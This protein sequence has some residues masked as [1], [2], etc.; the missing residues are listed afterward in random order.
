MKKMLFAIMLSLLFGCAAQNQL[1][2]SQVAS[3]KAL[4]T[5][6]NVQLSLAV[7][8][9]ALKQYVPVADQV[10]VRQFAQDLLQLSIGQ[11]DAATIAPL[12]PKLS[13]TAQKYIQPLIASALYAL[14]TAL[15]SLGSHNAQVLAYTQAVGNGLLQAG[16]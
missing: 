12:V 5:P 11:L 8:G 7:S 4:V 2:P 10:L 14:N 13:P 15:I 9:G 1:S 16:F 3:I 6:P